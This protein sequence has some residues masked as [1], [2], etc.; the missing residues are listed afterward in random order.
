MS[1]NLI[2]NIAHENILKAMESVRDLGLQP[3]VAK[4]KEAFEMFTAHGLP[5]KKNENY[6]YTSLEQHYTGKYL[7]SPFTT[8]QNINI[9][10][11]FKCD[12]P[13]LDT[14]LI[15]LTNGWYYESKSQPKLRKQNNGIIIGSL[16]E[17]MTQYPE[18]VLNYFGKAAETYTDELN[19]INQ[20][21]MQDGLF[22]FIPRGAKLDKPI[23]IINIV[24]ADESI[25]IYPR[26]L[27]ISESE[28]DNQLL[29]CDHSL[30]PSPF[31]MNGTME[32]FLKDNA[33][34]S[35]YRMQ[36][37][38]NHSVQL[39]NNFIRQ[40]KGSEF[41][42][43]FITLH[44]GTVRNNLWVDLMES[45]ANC[46]ING[47]WLADKNQHID[48]NTFIRHHSPQCNSNQ[49]FKGIL[50]DEATGIFSGKILVEKGAQ[51]TNAYQSN[52][53]LIINPSAKVRSKPQLEI[54]ADD[55]K[56]SHGSAT[57]KLDDDAMFYLRSRGISH[58]E[59]CQLLMFAFAGDITKQ[60]LIEPLKKEVEELIDKRLRGELSRCNR[61]AISCS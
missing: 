18:L 59:A 29:I 13:S 17:A 25:Q 28:E 26:H 12:V 50:D 41:H 30:N 21:L 39:T 35:F 20:A 42:S 54:Y 4:R 58:K 47:L 27:I 14:E 24:V 44:G 23:Q 36:N 32:V 6:K 57:G 53:N 52:K 15:I 8:S 19:T 31:I 38:H 11:V 51:K 34:L 61:C 60:I 33:K 3:I 56:C 55:V 1:T 40:S 10:D 7:Y 22:V 37:A 2:Q 46:N 45:E 49:L 16:L 43:V 5:N 9:D 48:Y